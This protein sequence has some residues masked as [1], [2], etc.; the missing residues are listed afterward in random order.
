MINNLIKRENLLLKS[1]TLDVIV[2][3]IQKQ[4]K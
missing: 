1:L 3:Y 4:M 2:S